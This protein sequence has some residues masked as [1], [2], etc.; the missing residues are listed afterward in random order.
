MRRLKALTAAIAGVGALIVA[1]AP[2]HAD[3]AAETWDFSG[4]TGPAGTPTS[5]S[6]WRTSAS[7]G[8]S[9]HLLDG[10]TF[11]VLYAYNEDAGQYNHP[12]ISPGLTEAAFVRCSTVGPKFGVHFIVW[13]QLLGPG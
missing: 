11:V 3:P 4:C 8:S 13:G 7:V 10:G 1:T 5:F 6:G 12:V 2:A 9:F